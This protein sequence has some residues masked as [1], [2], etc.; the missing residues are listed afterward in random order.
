MQPLELF[1]L[2]GFVVGRGAIKKGPD[3]GQHLPAKCSVVEIVSG[4][5]VALAELAQPTSPYTTLCV[6]WV[7]SAVR[8]WGYTCP[9]L[10][11]CWPRS[12]LFLTTP[13][14]HVRPTTK[15]V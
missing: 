7:R 11:N 6:I 8:C 1:T 4:V 10:V 2:S 9:W 13:R 12:G 5:A 15:P 14:S 3:L